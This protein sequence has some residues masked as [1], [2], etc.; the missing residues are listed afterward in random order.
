MAERSE[1]F[2]AAASV[3][4][5]AGV[6]P[7]PADFVTTKDDQLR[8]SSVNS[9][10]GV[11]LSVT[12]R[13]TDDTGLV[14]P[15]QF[16]HTPATDRSLTSD[17]FVLGAAARL[18][19]SVQASVGTPRIGQTY[20]LAQL[21]RGITGAQVILGTLFA[22]YVTGAQ[23]LGLP[24]SF[25][26]SSIATGGVIRA[27]AGTN[28]AVGAEVSETV[29]TGARWQLLAFRV[30]FATSGTAI[31]RRPTLVLQGNGVSVANIPLFAVVGE[32]TNATISWLPGAPVESSPTTVA[33]LALLPPEAILLAGDTITT[34]T[35]NLQPGDDYTG[36]NIL[37]RE[38]L[39]VSG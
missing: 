39:E 25:I 6:G 27:L 37:V 4:R 34:S 22:G 5:Q 30:G 31:N 33:M 2:F 28:P 3:L 38:W 7:A 14:T 21:V 9:L 26:E 29:P 8:I 19:L 1:R 17:D 24:G 35:I 15:V 13:V 36:P 20:V 16:L 32:N 12:G 10:V 18:N 11:T 23:P